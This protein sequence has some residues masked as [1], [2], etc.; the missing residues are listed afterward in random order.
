[1]VHFWQRAPGNRNYKRQSAV[2][3][4]LDATLNISYTAK[5]K[6]KLAALSYAGYVATTDDLFT[7]QIHVLPVICNEPVFIKFKMSFD[8]LYCK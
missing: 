5:K 1:M 2:S 3:L 8:L 6:K 7:E 4:D